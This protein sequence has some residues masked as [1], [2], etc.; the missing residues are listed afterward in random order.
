LGEGQ[1]KTVF[2]LRLSLEDRT[3]IEAAAERDGKPVSGWA[4]DV[5]MRSAAVDVSK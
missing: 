5:L 2:T 3:A 4:R 1:V